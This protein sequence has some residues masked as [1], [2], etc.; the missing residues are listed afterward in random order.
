MEKDKKEY[1]R[2]ALFVSLNLILSLFKFTPL[3][4][5]HD[6]LALKNAGR[7]TLKFDSLLLNLI[8]LVTLFRMFQTMHQSW[9]L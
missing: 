1:S 8:S 3:Q 9:S 6:L 4:L 7:Q 5:D 2:L